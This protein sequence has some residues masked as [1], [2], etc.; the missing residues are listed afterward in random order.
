MLWLESVLLEE[1]PKGIAAMRQSL[2]V[3]VVGTLVAVAVPASALA[4]VINWAGTGE[5][6]AGDI[7]N[8]AGAVGAPDA[9]SGPGATNFNL[10]AVANTGGT[11]TWGSF[12]GPGVSY[13]TASLEAL[14]GLSMSGVD[15]LAVEFNGS[16]GLGFE[17]SKWVFSDGVN[18]FA[19]EHISGGPLQPGIVGNVSVTSAAYTTFFGLSPFTPTGDFNF[20][21]FDLPSSV[22]TSSAAFTAQVSNGGGFDNGTPDIDA[23]G[24]IVPEPGAIA[25]LGLGLLALAARRSR[26]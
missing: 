7:I 10:A 11:G 15:F 25:F 2:G 1:G 22:D 3:L 21:L 24:V 20:L 23:M 5:E 18:T 19:T 9:D 26:S 17:G 4:T 13:D 6:T 14:L 16:A 12:I 8:P